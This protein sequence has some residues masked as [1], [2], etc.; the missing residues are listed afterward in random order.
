[1]Y[2]NV[3]NIIILPYVADDNECNATPDPCH[4]DAS[5]NNTIGSFECICDDGFDGNGTYCIGLLK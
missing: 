4:Q 3:T 5:C 2:F 1:M